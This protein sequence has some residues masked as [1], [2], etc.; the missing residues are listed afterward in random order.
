MSAN[1]KF[2]RFSGYGFHVADEKIGHEDF[3]IMTDRKHIT[4]EQRA[5]F[6]R[7]GFFV[8]RG[9]LTPDE[10][11]HYI[12]VVDRLDAEFRAEKGLAP[13]ATV[14]IRNSV[15]RSREL[16]GLLDHPS[17]FPLMVDLL[18]W[19]IQM[20]TSHVF[21]RTPT[22]AEAGTFKSIDWH[23]DGPSPRPFRVQTEA[24]EVEP[25]LYAKIGY[26]L[27]DLSKPDMGNLRVIPG[28]HKSAK[29]PDIDPATGEPE[30]AIQVLTEPGDAVFFENRTWHAVGPNYAPHARK[31]VY[32]G[33]CYRW[34]KP[35]DFVTQSEELLAQASPVQRQLLGH[36]TDALS[37]YLP[38]RYK[39]D[40][41]LREW[42]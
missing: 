2:L 37:C 22:P 15:A 41:P 10:V 38:D 33:Y 5:A 16:L 11:R 12:G 20:T 19:N 6:E 24:G 28:S 1:V 40:V 21:V 14:E 34:V 17:A 32:M 23:A 3:N 13:D 8:L 29:R 18:G 4:A 25:R 31:N 9:A 27:T 7:D 26:F 30:G 35:I 39:D 42:L 36:V